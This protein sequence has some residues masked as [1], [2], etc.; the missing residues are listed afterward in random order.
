MDLPYPVSCEVIARDC[1]WITHHKANQTSSNHDANEII[2]LILH[3]L[4]P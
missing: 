3:S 1:R 4:M 2:F